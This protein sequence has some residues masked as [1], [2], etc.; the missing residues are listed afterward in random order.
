MENLPQIFMYYIYVHCTYTNKIYC[1]FGFPRFKIIYKKSSFQ[2]YSKLAFINIQQ[3][4]SEDV[5]NSL[6]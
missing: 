4:K 2:K 6:L 3:P 1:A 5:S